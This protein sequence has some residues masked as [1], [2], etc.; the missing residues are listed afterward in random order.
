[1][2]WI[3]YRIWQRSYLLCQLWQRVWPVSERLEHWLTAA[4]RAHP[5]LKTKPVAISEVDGTAHKSQREAAFQYLLTTRFNPVNHL[6]RANFGSFSL[7]VFYYVI[8]WAER[9]KCTT[10]IYRY[11]A[12]DVVNAFSLCFYEQL[13]ICFVN[14]LTSR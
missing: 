14:R 1:M 13:S 4:R 10:R 3:T 5:T 12:D 2:D 6:E 11:N 9:V 8:I 7:A